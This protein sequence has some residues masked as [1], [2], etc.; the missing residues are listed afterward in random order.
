MNIFFEFNPISILNLN[1]LYFG[2]IIR[3]E[4]SGMFI[5]LI[6]F[7]MSSKSSILLSFGGL[8]N[9]FEGSVF[10]YSIDI[11]LAVLAGVVV[12]VIGVTV[13]GTEFA[14]AVTI[15]VLIVVSNF[16]RIS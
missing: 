6:H 4:S 1:P 9:T 2:Y 15:G 3:S 13:A 12:V 14:D 11:C 8:K 5:L 7:L 16:D 10:L